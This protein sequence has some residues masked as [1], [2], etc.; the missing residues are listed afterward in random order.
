MA[1]WFRKPTI[2]ELNRW[3]KKTAVALLGIEITDVGDDYIKGC[4]PVDDRTRQPM[5]LLHGGASV[6]FAESLASIA[7]NYCVD[8]DR[9]YCVGLDINANHIRGVREGMV[10]G[11]AKPLHIG[12][13]TQVWEIKITDQAGHLVCVSRLTL[14]VVQKST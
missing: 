14:A 12:R 5:G 4:M 2:D 13:S 3:G 6:L 10:A 8:P 9:V 11:I 1:I 7:A